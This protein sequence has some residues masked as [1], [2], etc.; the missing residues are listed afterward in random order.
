[1]I[2]CSPKGAASF[3]SDSYGGSASDRQIIGKSC[4]LDPTT[5]I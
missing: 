2:G 5:E 1:M 4:L 3:L